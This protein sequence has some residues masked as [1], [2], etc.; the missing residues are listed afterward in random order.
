ARSERGRWILTRGDARTLPDAPILRLDAVLGRV[1]AVRRREAL[2]DPPAA[3]PDSLLRGLVVG[4]CRVA[5]DLSAPAGA[6]V[7]KLM[8]AGRRALL[9]AVSLV[10][11][12]ATSGAPD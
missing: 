7:L 10:R 3:P 4:L 11:G 12:R 5:L 6:G 2:V 8:V 1:A 9:G